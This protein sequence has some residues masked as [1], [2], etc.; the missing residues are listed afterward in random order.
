MNDSDRE[1]VEVQINID[2]DKVKRKRNYFLRHIKYYYLENKKAWNI[3]ITLL[4]LVIIIYSLLN[5]FVFNKTYLYSN[6]FRASD[7]TMKIDDCYL[8]TED[9]YGNKITD[10]GKSLIAVN[11]QIKTTASGV[12]DT[13]PTYRTALLLN[14]VHYYPTT[15]YRDRI[16]D[17]GLTYDGQKIDNTYNY[18]LLTYE[19][20]TSDLNK[21][22]EF[23]YMIGYNFG[24]TIEPNI[25]H[26]SL[27]YKNLDGETKETTYNM[28]DIAHLNESVASDVNLSIIKSE[29]NTTFENDYSFCSN[30]F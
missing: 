23:N 21:N 2:T 17:L 25:I 28:N 27:G 6:Y 10:N 7:F 26:V 18:Y 19:V 1:E 13:L 16:S 22:M 24:K 3:T 30:S 11:I 15:K 5:N 14:N 9:N 4:M 8:L 12:V 29:I 20:P